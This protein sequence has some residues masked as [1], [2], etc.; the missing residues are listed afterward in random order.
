[1]GEHKKNEKEIRC[2]KKEYQSPLIKATVLT[3]DV[4]RTSG[5]DVVKPYTYDWFFVAHGEGNGE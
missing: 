3:Q 1:M 4:V 2:M 5:W